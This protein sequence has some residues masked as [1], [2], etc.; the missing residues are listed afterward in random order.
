MKGG[1]RKGEGGGEREERNRIERRANITL[2]LNGST[3]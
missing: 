2:R 3:A 1:E